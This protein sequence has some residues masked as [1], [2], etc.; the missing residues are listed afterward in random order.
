MNDIA[1]LFC[2]VFLL[3]F[4]VNRAFHAILKQSP[5]FELFFDQK[6]SFKSINHMVYIE[7]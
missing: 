7:I 1:A 5:S 6:I 3:N 4:K 2:F